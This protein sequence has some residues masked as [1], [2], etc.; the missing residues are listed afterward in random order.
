MMLLNMMAY[1]IFSCDQ[2]VLAL[3]GLKGGIVV[4]FNF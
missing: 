2:K 3:N 4:S 1:Y